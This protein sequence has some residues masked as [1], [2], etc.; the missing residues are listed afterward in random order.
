VPFASDPLFSVAHALRVKGFAEAPAVAEATGH[1]PDR[2]LAL[3]SELADAELVER[4]DRG[5][6]GWRL[7]TEGRKTHESWLNNERVAA[8]CDAE[9]TSGYDTFLLRNEEFKVLCTDWQLRPVD[10]ALAPNDHTDE[11]YDAAIVERLGALH[12][13]VVPAVAALADALVRFGPYSARLTSACGRVQGGDRSA[14]ARP[15]SGS[16]HDVWMELHQDLLLTLGRERG[17]ADGH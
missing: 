8:G 15:L 4:R 3:L 9:I 7:T 17:D 10:G 1:P 13:S 6:T 2:A 16:Y 14:I 5:I 12:D 11:A